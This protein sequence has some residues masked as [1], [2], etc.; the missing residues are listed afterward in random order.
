MEVADITPLGNTAAVAPVP[1]L[2][3][4]DNRSDVRLLTE[5]FAERGMA[6]RLLVAQTIKEVYGFMRLLPE[7]ERPRLVIADLSLPIASGHEIL[8]ML[9][10]DPRWQSIQKV[11]LS[12]SEREEDRAASFAAGA[13]AHL[14][15]PCCFDG[16]LLIADRIRELLAAAKIRV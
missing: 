9:G 3:I 5:A 4:E 13:I 16:V 12:S 11:V 15:K 1:I 2:L 8:R 6:V 14:V 7:G 10:S